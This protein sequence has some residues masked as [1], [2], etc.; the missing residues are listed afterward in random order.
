MSQGVVNQLQNELSLE[1]KDD[2]SAEEIASLSADEFAPKAFDAQSAEAVG[3][4][5]YSYWRCTFQAFWKNKMARFLLIALCALLVFTII[6][7]ALPGQKDPNEIFNDYDKYGKATPMKNKGPSAEYWFG[8]DAVGHDLWSRIWSGTRTSL[9]M[10]L[11]VASINCVVGITIGVMWGYV[12]RLDALLTEIYN[13][14]DNIPRTI[15]LI[16][17]SYIMKPGMLTM[18][19]SM[20]IVG[21]LGMAR[22][23]RNQVVM[24]RD[25]D[26]NLA[27]RCLGTDTKKI[28]FRNLLP[29]LVSVIMLQTA[30]AIPMVISD[31]VFLTY[32]GLGMPKSVASLGGLVEDGRKVM[33]SPTLRYQLIFPALVVTF[34]TVSFYLI[35]NAFADAS[36]PRNHV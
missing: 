21:W 26:Y 4:S 12:R 3:Y 35:G 14:M 18:I 2:L 33:M 30:L 27:S 10:A 22:F 11:I 17:M 13:I 7:P 32:C 8:T 15:I 25:R 16:L 20:C 5:N 34:I 9:L 28:M 36:D 31:E 29:Y 19:V 6:Q 23:I 1:E 24:I